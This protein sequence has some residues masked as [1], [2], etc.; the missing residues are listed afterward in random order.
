MKS[1]V[2]EDAGKPEHEKKKVKF[3]VDSHPKH[4][5][6]GAYSVPDFK[7][8]V[9]VPSEKDLDESIDGNLT[10]IADNA[11]IT[12]KGGEIFFSHVRR[13]GSS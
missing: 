1:D 10:P 9:G 4:L 11:T 8:L 6:P 12:I 5:P 7:E 13:G 2:Y 3:E